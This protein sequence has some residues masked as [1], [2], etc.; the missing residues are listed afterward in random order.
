MENKEYQYYF[1]KYGI[2][3]HQLSENS[4]IDVT[5]GHII[6]FKYSDGISQWHRFD[7][8][9]WISPTTTF[10]CDWFIND[11]NVTK[12]ITQWAEYNG[13]DLYN[14]SPSDIVLIKLTWNNYA[15]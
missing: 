8:P 3:R 11:K 6:F 7:G 2:G 4:F 9:A 12:Q 10:D 5:K 13:L 14:L 15:K 1:K